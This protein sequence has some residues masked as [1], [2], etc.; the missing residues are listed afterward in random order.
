MTPDARGSLTVNGTVYPFLDVTSA[1]SVVVQVSGDEIVMPAW[2][3]A[4]YTVT[5]PMALVGTLYTALSAITFA[6]DWLVTYTFAVSNAV[7]GAWTFGGVTMPPPSLPLT[8]SFTPIATPEP[9]S[10]LLLGFGLLGLR[11]AVRRSRNPA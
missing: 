8:T 6:G 9:A 3:G 7:P 10:L 11:R 4:T 2:T 1:N 5:Q